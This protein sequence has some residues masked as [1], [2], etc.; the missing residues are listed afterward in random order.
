MK[1]WQQELREELQSG[2]V[3]YTEDGRETRVELE[4][5]PQAGALDLQWKDADDRQWHL[6]IPH[7][8]LMAVMDAMAKRLYPTARSKRRTKGTGG[9][10]RSGE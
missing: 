3:A 8:M 2:L 5:D 10:A 7:A 1:E 6:T 4:F 9:G